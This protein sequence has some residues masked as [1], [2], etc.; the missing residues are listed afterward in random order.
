MRDIIVTFNN[1]RQAR[2]T[3]AVYDLLTTDNNVKDIID[4]ETG[5]LLFTRLFGGEGVYKAV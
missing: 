1:G 5:E 2:Y 3:M 4:A